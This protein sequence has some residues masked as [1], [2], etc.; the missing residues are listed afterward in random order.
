MTS[1]KDKSTILR[2]Q[3]LILIRNVV[4]VLDGFRFFSFIF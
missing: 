1:A 2:I 3:I 4:S